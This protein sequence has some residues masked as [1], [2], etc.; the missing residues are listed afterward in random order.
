MKKILLL[1]AIISAGFYSKA[2]SQILNPVRWS[3]AAKKISNKEATVYMKATID[4]GW[5]MYS[6]HVKDG[7]P[8]KTT[9]TFTPSKNFSLIGS[10]IEPQAIVKRE[11]VFKMDVSYFEKSVV[12]QQKIKL[13]AKQVLVSG[14]IEFMVCNDKQCLPPEDIKFNVAIK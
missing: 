12:F 11:D 9:I 5:H 7:G 8:V 10:T 1:V 3:Y 2:S 4:D 13:N 6:Q 14:T